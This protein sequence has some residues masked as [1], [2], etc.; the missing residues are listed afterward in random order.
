MLLVPG[1][2]LAQVQLVGLPGQAAVPGENPA[3]AS[4]SVFVKTGVMGTSAADAVVVAMWHLRG[5][6]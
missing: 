3:K 4:R 2:V 6:G 5:S 1:R